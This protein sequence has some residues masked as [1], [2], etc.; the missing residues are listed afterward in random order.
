MSRVVVRPPSVGGLGGLE[1]PDQRAIRFADVCRMFCVREVGD[2]VPRFG[3]VFGIEAVSKT[4]TFALGAL[5]A[6]LAD[7][8]CADLE[9]AAGLLTL[10]VAELI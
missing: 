5:P 1:I 10:F 2:F 7:P 6:Q 3:D 8:A 4:E 9:Q